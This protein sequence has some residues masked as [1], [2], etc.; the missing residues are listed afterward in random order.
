MT[1]VLEKKYSFT[2]N[3]ACCFTF[4]VKVSSKLVCPNKYY[5]PLAVG[6]HYSSKSIYG[7]SIRFGVQIQPCLLN[8]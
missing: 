7:K 4:S 3:T 1:N 6:Y 8:T 2:A 5:F